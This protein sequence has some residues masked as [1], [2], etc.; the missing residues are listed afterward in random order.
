LHCVFATASFL[1]LG[2]EPAVSLPAR[3]AA[4]ER[5]ACGL[6]GASGLE[7]ARRV[8]AGTATLS[9]ES[10]CHVDYCSGA[11]Q[12]FG[13][14]LAVR[15]PEG[16]TAAEL[17]QALRCHGAQ[18]LLQAGE[19]LENDPFFLPD[20]WV[21]IDVAPRERG[22]FVVTLTGETVTDN[23]RVLRRAKAFARSEQQRAAR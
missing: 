3:A 10:S 7:T 22:I 15:P 5:D 17:A 4:V 8:V 16:V 9:A 23:I 11:G 12:I 14:R 20:S 19:R 21:D 6:S 2:C 13:A 18:A 1:A